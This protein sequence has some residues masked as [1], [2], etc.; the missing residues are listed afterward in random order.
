MQRIRIGL[1]GLAFV[2]LLVLLG[3]AISRSGDDPLAAS[4]PERAGHARGA[5][6][7]AGRDRRRAGHRTL[8]DNETGEDRR[9]SKHRERGGA[10][11]LAIAAAACRHWPRSAVSADRDER[12]RPRPPAERP[13]LALLTSLPL[14]FG[15]SFG[16]DSG[17]SAALTRLEQRYNVVADRGRRCGQPGRAATAADGP[18]ARPAGR[19][20]GRARPVGARRRASA[21]ARRSQARLAERAA[22][23]R[24][25]AAAAGLRR[26]RAAGALG[27]EAER[28]GPAGTGG[29]SDRTT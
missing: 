14:V 20:A 27:T 17:G 11:W 26:H 19:G 15:E 25:A 1:T 23:G 6:R 5:E 8:D 4:C 9:P 13:T 2:F 7:A 10:C 28:P 29:A 24:P 22:A 12:C 16:L 21:A 18:S 3:T